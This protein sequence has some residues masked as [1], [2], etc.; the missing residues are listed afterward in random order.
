MWLLVATQPFLSH[1]VLEE[2][3]NFGRLTP[4]DSLFVLYLRSILATPHL[5]L[6]DFVLWPGFYV[7][8]SGSFS[9]KNYISIL[10]FWESAFS[11]YSNGKLAISFPGFSLFSSF[12]FWPVSI[13]T[14]IWF[15]TPQSSFSLRGWNHRF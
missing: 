3:V 5:F 8:R 14:L 2:C 15:L 6:L 1:A 11:T 9:L 4:F 10:H 7:S 12:F 13:F